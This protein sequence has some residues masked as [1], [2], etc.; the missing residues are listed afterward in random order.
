MAWG[1]SANYVNRS[2]YLVLETHTQ[3]EKRYPHYA[4]KSFERRDGCGVTLRLLF[5][6][7]HRSGGEI[8]VVDPHGQTMALV[9]EF[10][11]RFVVWVHYIRAE[12]STRATE[13][14]PHYL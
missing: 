11:G 14:F 9:L 6:P 5:G 8:I 2:P 13:R 3:K 4:E 12:S 10:Q 7:H 1:K